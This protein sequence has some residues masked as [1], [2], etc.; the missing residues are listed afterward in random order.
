M[1]LV[2]ALSMFLRCAGFM[3]V[4]MGCMRGEGDATSQMEYWSSLLFDMATWF[5]KIQIYSFLYLK[6]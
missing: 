3:C 1:K 5:S 4:V 2:Q 6:R